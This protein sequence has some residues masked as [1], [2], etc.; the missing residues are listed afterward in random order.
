MKAIYQTSITC[1][2]MSKVKN[3]RSVRKEPTGVAMFGMVYFS[4]NP[5][6]TYLCKT[7]AIRV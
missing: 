1:M 7:L 4:V 6:L 5:P 3:S 2:K